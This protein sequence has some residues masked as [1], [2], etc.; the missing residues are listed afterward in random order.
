MTTICVK[1]YADI[2]GKSDKTVYKMVKNGH[3]QSVK[4]DKVLHVVV[5][6]HML[7]AYQSICKK[8]DTLDEKVE[9]IIERLDAMAQR[10]K[11]TKSV[12]KSNTKQP[13]KK[14]LSK[15]KRPKNSSSP[16]KR[17]PLKKVATKRLVKA[18]K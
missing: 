3:L 7:E 17:K 13:A 12:K 4:R 5:D 1:E 10:E 11:S 8:Y 15:K 2:I 6:Q 18:K 16:K 9:K 14:T